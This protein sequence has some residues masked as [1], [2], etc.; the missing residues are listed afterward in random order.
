LS[1]NKRR[2]YA[3]ISVNCWES[4]WWIGEKGEF[5]VS[6]GEMSHWLGNEKEAL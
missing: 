4:L 6:L 5:G 2:L 1:G 3:E